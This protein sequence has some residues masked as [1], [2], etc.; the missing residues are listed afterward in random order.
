MSLHHLVVAALVLVHDHHDAAVVL[1][2]ESSQFV[3]NVLALVHVI[4]VVD[5]VGNAV[6]DDHV[7]ALNLD[8]PAHKLIAGNV[9]IIGVNAVDIGITQAGDL[10]VAMPVL[11]D[12]GLDG[13]EDAGTVVPRLLGVDEP[14]LA[15]LDQ[16]LAVGKNVR[17]QKDGTQDVAEERLAVFPLGTHGHQV[18]LGQGGHVTDADEVIG[19]GIIDVAIDYILLLDVG[20]FFGSLF[21]G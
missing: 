19:F 10:D 20:K 13:L 9:I 16:V 6:N 8:G 7:G 3:N 2:G 5:E 1:V 11:G 15:M 14:H 12:D 18:A 21:L 4:V 17:A